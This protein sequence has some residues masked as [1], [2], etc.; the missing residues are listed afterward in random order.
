M[1][2]DLLYLFLSK[3]GLASVQ[4]KSQANTTA[5]IVSSENHYS[6]K[7]S[8]NIK[9]VMVQN[10]Y[11]ETFVKKTIDHCQQCNDT[12]IQT[13]SCFS[14]REPGAALSPLAILFECVQISVFC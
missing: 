2:F 4:Q 10:G 8:T 6:S 14:V 12:A 9:D 3:K 1:T 7:N 11:P 13:I 5:M